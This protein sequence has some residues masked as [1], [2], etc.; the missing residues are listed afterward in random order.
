MHTTWP[1]YKSSHSRLEVSIL[2]ASPR[3][4]LLPSPSFPSP[5]LLAFQ[6]YTDSSF[7]LRLLFLCLLHLHHQNHRAH[8]E[9]QTIHR[10][11]DSK[12]DH[13]NPSLSRISPCKPKWT[14]L[15]MILLLFLFLKSL[16]HKMRCHH[17]LGS[18]VPVRACHGQRVNLKP[19]SFRARQHKAV[20]ITGF[21]IPCQNSACAC[22]W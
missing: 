18:G 12:M 5:R 1:L 6:L 15:R 14:E 21:V 11:M 17:T 16:V 10:V 2:S 19:V 13:T 3:P 7:T 22:G 9:D 8:I 20:M 4:V